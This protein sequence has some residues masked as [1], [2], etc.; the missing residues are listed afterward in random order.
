[1]IT[2]M[3]HLWIH[4][5]TEKIQ[6]VNTN[7]E[8]YILCSNYNIMNSLRMTM[9]NQAANT[10]HVTSPLIEITHDQVSVHWWVQITCEF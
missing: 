9:P 1:M 5:L 3:Q 10:F 7:V 4:E 6:T 2:Q 8:N